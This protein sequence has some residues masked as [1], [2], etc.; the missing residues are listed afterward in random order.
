M[1]VLQHVFRLYVALD[2]FEQAIA[3]YEWIQGLSCERR[4]HI[5]ET[6]MDAAK[7]G[8]FLI[9]TGAPQSLA[10]VRDVN[11]IFYVD[12]LAAFV[13]WLSE[14]GAEI[15]AGPRTVTGGRNA[16]VRNPDGLIVE[17]F[18]AMR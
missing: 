2:K 1:Q 3:F 18:E 11:A 17:Y 16:T 13:P 14:N 7:V 10:R 4:V 8:G 9:F 6:G 15:L 5:P 12:S